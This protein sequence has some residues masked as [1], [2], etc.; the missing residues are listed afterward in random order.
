LVH[1]NRNDS[2]D[3]VD[4]VEDF[5]QKEITLAPPLRTRTDI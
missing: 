2:I 5:R 1:G 3:A 4:C